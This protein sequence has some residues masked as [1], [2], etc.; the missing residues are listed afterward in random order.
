MANKGTTTIAQTLENQAREW[1]LSL[2]TIENRSKISARCAFW[3]TTMAARWV[4][5]RPMRNEDCCSD[6]RWKQKGC[7]SK[8][9]DQEHHCAVTR[10]TTVSQCQ[11]KIDRKT[12]LNSLVG[13]L[14]SRH[15]EMALPKTLKVLNAL[16]QGKVCI[17]AAAT[18]M[19]KATTRARATTRNSISSN[20][21]NSPKLV[22]G[23]SSRQIAA[24]T[25]FNFPK[26]QIRN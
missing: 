16:L 10:P 2:S 25:T 18:A 26:R 1:A 3:R 4:Q 17:T 8:N 7:G 19:A 15:I 6:D 9:G 21:G 12:I 11:V 5:R 20:N 24:K 23:K 14:A 13:W 22:S